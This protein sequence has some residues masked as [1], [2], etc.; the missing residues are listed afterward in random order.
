M[1]EDVILQIP[2]HPSSQ[3]KSIKPHSSPKSI[4]FNSKSSQ[5][6]QFNQTDTQSLSSLAGRDIIN[7]LKLNSNGIVLM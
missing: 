6:N 7:K 4:F 5:I 1:M 3:I 2:L